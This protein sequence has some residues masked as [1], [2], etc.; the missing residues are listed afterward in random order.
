MV[1]L[2]E[3]RLALQAEMAAV[4]SVGVM[5]GAGLHHERFLVRRV[6]LP[7]PATTPAYELTDAGAELG[8]AVMALAR[9]G[10]K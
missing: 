9:W 7:P 8:P 6:T 5:H 10:L 1:A 2:A 4:R 3:L